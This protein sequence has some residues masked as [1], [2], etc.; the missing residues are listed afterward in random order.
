MSM[1]TQLLYKFV[2]FRSSHIT[3]NGKRINVLIA[4]MF[5]SQMLGLMHRPGLRSNEGMLF[6]FGTDRRWGIWMANM[7][8]SIDIVWIDRKW[9]VADIKKNVKPCSSIFNCE[10]HSPVAESRYVLELPSGSASR[11]R[12]KKGDKIVYKP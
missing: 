2:K 10:T 4:D 5:A 11:H 1:F 12:I 8:F 7:R 9:R 3:V 6:L